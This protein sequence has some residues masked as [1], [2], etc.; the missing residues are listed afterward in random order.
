MYYGFIVSMRRNLG[1]KG[2]A[3]RPAY[4]NNCRHNR[5]FSLSPMTLLCEFYNNRYP[6]KEQSTLEQAYYEKKD[7][8]FS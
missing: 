6:E 7:R 5:E 1:L 3:F 2:L 8:H 4:H